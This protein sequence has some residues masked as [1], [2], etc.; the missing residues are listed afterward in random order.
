MGGDPL[1]LVLKWVWVIPEPWTNRNCDLERTKHL[2]PLG[3]LTTTDCTVTTWTIPNPWLE[4]AKR[5]GRYLEI[6]RTVVGMATRYPFI[7]G[8]KA[9]QPPPF[10]AIPHRVLLVFAGDGHCATEVCSAVCLW[11]YDHVSR[12]R[13]TLVFDDGQFLQDELDVDVRYLCSLQVYHIFLYM[14]SLKP[15]LTFSSFVTPLMYWEHEA[16]FPYQTGKLRSCELWATI[17]GNFRRWI[18]FKST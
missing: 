17:L 1:F 8:T 16:L 5:P 9:F 6:W 14:E 12:R 11:L 7:R 18:W 3:Q 10:H 2:A 4:A 15:E 13:V